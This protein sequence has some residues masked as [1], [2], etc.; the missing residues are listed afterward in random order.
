MSANTEVVKTQ[1]CA[2]CEKRTNWY[3]GTT[4]YLQDLE[5]VTDAL[6]CG[7]CEINYV[8]ISK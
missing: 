4:Q 3:R 1:Y 7:C 8:G 5:S 2:F 6:Y